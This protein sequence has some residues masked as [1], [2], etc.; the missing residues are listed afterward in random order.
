MLL[1]TAAKWLALSDF[2]LTIGL[3]LFL[4]FF[5][6]VCFLEID[7]KKIKSLFTKK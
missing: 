3:F 4:S 1:Q 6:G 2:W 5:F 7:F